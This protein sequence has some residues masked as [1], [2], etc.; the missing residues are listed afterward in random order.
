MNIHSSLKFVTLEQLSNDINYLYFELKQA[1]KSRGSDLIIQQ[2]ETNDG[3]V[4][5]HNLIQKY[6]Y[7]G[8]I[9]TYKTKLLKTIYNRYHTGYPGGAIGYLDDWEDATT[10]YENIA[11][12]EAL[13]NLS[14]IHI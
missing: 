1:L 6:R 12:K 7:G 8:D 9:E 5:Y 2:N 10:R 11:P 3:I 14:L 13:T 4:V